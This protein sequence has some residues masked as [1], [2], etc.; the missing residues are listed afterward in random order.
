MRSYQETGDETPILVHSPDFDDDEIQL[1][2]LFRTYSEMPDLEQKALQLCNG[3]VLDVGCGAGIH[4]LYL[5]NE[6]NLKVSAIDTSEGAAQIAAER[7]VQDVRNIDFFSIENE[8]YDTILLLMN[9][10]GIIGSLD[11]IPRF[12]DKLKQLLYSG[13]VVIMDSSDLIFL[14]DDESEA[15][16]L[17]NYYGELQFQVSY[18]EE[19]SAWFD[20]LYLDP[21]RLI[22]EAAKNGFSCEIFAKGPH[23]DYLAILRKNSSN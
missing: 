1:P 19:R 5:Q 8:H 2:Y 7:G 9:G 22:N 11:R 6:R 15:N 23:Y 16:E 12:F 20:W 14:F 18:K 3:S 10:T 4:S 21:Q 13:G 17:E